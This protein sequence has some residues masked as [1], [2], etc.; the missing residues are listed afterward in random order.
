MPIREAIYVSIENRVGENDEKAVHTQVKLFFGDLNIS[1]E[2]KEVV[3]KTV[4]GS[5][6]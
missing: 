2:K 6:V 4:K 5:A 1:G 3:L